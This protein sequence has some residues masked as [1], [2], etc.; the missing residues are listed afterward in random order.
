MINNNNKNN[1]DGTTQLLE[2][3]V[4]GTAAVINPVSGILYMGEDVIVP[5]GEGVGP[6]AQ[7]LWG[8]IVI[9]SLLVSLE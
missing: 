8:E 4:A 1:N 6:V 9:I 5:T 3:F 7:K 2:A